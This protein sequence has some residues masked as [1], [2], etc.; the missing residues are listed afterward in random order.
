MFRGYVSRYVS[1]V[2]FAA[3]ELP[4]LSKL[5]TRQKNTNPYLRSRVRPVL[6]KRNPQY[7]PIGSQEKQ[8]APFTTCILHG[9]RAAKVGV[10]PGI[11]TAV[12]TA[13]VQSTSRRCALHVGLRPGRILSLWGPSLNPRGLAQQANS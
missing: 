10:A 4:A 1:G 6:L 5:D 9:L 7:I 12:C 8:A 11:S 13:A 2:C 3:V